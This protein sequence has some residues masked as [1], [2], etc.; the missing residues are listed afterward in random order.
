MDQIEIW[1]RSL[2]EQLTKNESEKETPGE[3]K[4]D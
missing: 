3:K 1:L 4:T 2:A